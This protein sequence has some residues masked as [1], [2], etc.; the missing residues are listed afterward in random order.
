M[1]YIIPFIFSASLSLLLTLITKKIA[2]RYGKVAIPRDDRW[3][4]TPTAFLGGVAIYLSFLITAGIFNVPITREFIGIFAGATILFATGLIDDFKSIRPY[5]KLIAQI[6]AVAVAILFDIKIEIFTPLLSVP[7]TILWVIAVTNAFNLLDNMDGLSAGI[8]FITSIVL[9]IVSAIYNKPEL[10]T[11]SLILAGTSLGFLRYNFKPASIFMGDCGSM[12]LG[13]IIGTLSVIGTRHHAS[14]FI[15]TIAIP[16]L[17]LAVP[18]FD[19]ALVTIMRDLT[20]RSVSRGGKDHISHRLVVLGLSEKKAVLLLY[21]LA[22]ITGSIAIIYPYVNFYVVTIIGALILVGLFFLGV[23]LG[24]TKVYSEEELNIAKEKI[25]G[26]RDKTILNTTFFYKRQVIEVLIDFVLIIVAYISAYLLRFE[27]KIPEGDLDLFIKSL[28][29]FI[30]IQLASFYYFGLYKKIWKY[31][32][33]DDVVSIFKAV[34]TGA[35]L[36]VF[37]LVL[38]IRFAGYSRAVFVIYWLILIVLTTSVRG[39]LRLLRERF[40]EIKKLG[41]K[42]VLIFGAGDAGSALLREIKNNPEL[43]YKV[44]GFIDDDLKRIGRRIYGKTVIGSG[45]DLS[46]I[47][48]DKNV[49]EVLIAISHLNDENRQRIEKL[50]EESGLT[51]RIMGR[52]L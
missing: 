15:V 49:G 3:H 9:S 51:Y 39:A 1:K 37:V 10:V 48:K 32:G 31:I 47:A 8:A 17:I 29:I 14:N 12:F 42:R 21:L 36:T 52:M 2:I 5:T 27:G 4:N 34:T 38:I 28:P 43:N 46:R 22:I 26:N 40:A 11:I 44:I 45:A 25:L 24:E 30:L 7:L 33:L 6:T 50:C 20:G 35:L 19:T 18:I 13:F 16:V 41:G 23:F